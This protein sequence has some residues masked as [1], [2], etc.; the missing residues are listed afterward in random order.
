MPSQE[1][2]LV[3]GVGVG[4][5]GYPG[6]GAMA[7]VYKQMSKDGGMGWGAGVSTTGSQWA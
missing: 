2:R 5:G 6:Y 3:A 4:V 1:H 7:F